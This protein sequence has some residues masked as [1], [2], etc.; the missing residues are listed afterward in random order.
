MDS[1]VR[2]VVDPVDSYPGLLL[3]PLLVLLL[4][5]LALLLLIVLAI[6]LTPPRSHSHSHKQS[7][8][9]ALVR[10]NFRCW[11]L[12]YYGAEVPP[13]SREYMDPPPAP[14]FTWDKLDSNNTRQSHQLYL[15]TFLMS[16]VEARIACAKLVG[17][18]S[19]G[20]GK[21]WCYSPLPSSCNKFY[22]SCAT[23][24]NRRIL[25]S[26]IKFLVLPVMCMQDLYPVSKCCIA[27]LS[28]FRSYSELFPDS[29][30]P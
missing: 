13:R 30:S 25:I 27:L 5:L 1:L 24:A 22:V 6:P 10:F 8:P 2:A 29:A 23:Q 7:D 12:R 21:F 4:L 19:C 26:D 18:R 3:L 9:R 15:D 14:Y 20:S 11:V 16:N 17:V 28:L